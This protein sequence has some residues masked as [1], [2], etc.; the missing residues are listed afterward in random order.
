MNDIIFEPA[1]VIA[2]EPSEIEVLQ[3]KL[4]EVRKFRNSIQRNTTGSRKEYMRLKLKEKHVQQKVDEYNKLHKSL[5][6]FI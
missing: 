2:D 3:Q 6:F 5:D 1:K 4:D